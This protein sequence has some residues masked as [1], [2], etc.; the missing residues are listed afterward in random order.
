MS[1]L[2]RIK[3]AFRKAPKPED[4]PVVTIFGVSA[5]LSVMEKAAEAMQAE[6]AN[7][8]DYLGKAAIAGHE[9][10][11]AV[12]AGDLD[13]A[14]DL[15][16]DQK[17]LYLQ[18]ANQW[19]W[20]AQDT[21]ALTASLDKN[22]ANIL[23]LKGRHHDA[24]PHV[25]YWAAAQAHRPSKH[26]GQKIRA[27]FNRCKLKNTTLDEVTAFVALSAEHPDLRAIQDKVQEWI[28]RG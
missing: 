16:L 19:E 14:W 22:L 20:N 24:L 6:S 10:I 13:K 9:S 15:Y 3:S 7:R 8:V 17:S 4:D 2:D 18:H 26:H 25:L 27:Y 1:L 12:R 11:A 28:A 23:R 5:P 21:I